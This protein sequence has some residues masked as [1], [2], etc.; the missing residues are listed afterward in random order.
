MLISPGKKFEITLMLFSWACGKM[1]HEKTWSEKSLDAVPLIQKSL[2]LT[3][4]WDN[5]LFST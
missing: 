1:I 4:Y 5:G 3:I 2:S